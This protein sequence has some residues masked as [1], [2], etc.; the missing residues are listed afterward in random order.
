MITR[1]PFQALAALCCLVNAV[2]SGASTFTFEDLPLG[3]PGSDGST[4]YGNSGTYF[5][6]GSNTAGGFTAGSPAGTATFANSYNTDFGFWSSFA[7]SNT[8]DTTTAGFTNQYSAFAGMGAGGSANYVIAYPPGGE[9][10]VNFSNPL[11]FTGGGLS[12]TNTTYAALSM[13]DGDTFAKKFGG[14]SGDDPDFFRLTIEGW[15]GAVS[16][17]TVDFYLAD[18]RFADNSLDYIVSDWAFVDLSVFGT[19]VSKLTFGLA[20]SDTGVFGIN[21]PTYFALDNIVA[22]PE[23]GIYAAGIGALALLVIWQRRRR[24]G[25]RA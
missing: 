8:T 15:S 11:D 13:R 10:A 12:L 21:T 7:Y 25:D 18:Y 24:Q 20:S 14:V 6:N 19:D 4:P 5:W 3:N 2:S 17:G 23:P 9:W 1:R 22:V 16:L